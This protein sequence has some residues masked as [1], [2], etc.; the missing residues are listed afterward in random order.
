MYIY[1][2]VQY[3]LVLVP[4]KNQYVQYNVLHNTLTKGGGLC[5]HNS[6]LLRSRKGTPKKKISY[7]QAAAFKKSVV[8]PRDFFFNI[9]FFL[10]NPTP[11]FLPR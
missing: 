7:Q 2:Q 1:V 10:G 9:F 6:I 11:S 8:S 5:I 4:T 3:I